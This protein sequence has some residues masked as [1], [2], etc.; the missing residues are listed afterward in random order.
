MRPVK[1]VALLHDICS[2]GKASLTNM[3]PILGGMGVE[4]CPIPTM[5][6]STHT[7]GYDAPAIHKIP[8]SYIRACADHYKEQEIQFD[9]IFVGYLGDMELIDSVIYF[10]ES[11]PDTKVIMDPIMGDHGKL[12][13]N[14]TEEYPKALRRL[15]PYADVLLPNLTE[16]FLLAGVPYQNPDDHRYVLTLCKELARLGAKNLV[17][18][19][20]E[21]DDCKK[22]IVLYENQAFL[23]IGNGEESGEYHGAGDAF[24]GMFVAKQ[25]Q[26]YSLLES[27]QASHA[28]VCACIRESM[29]YDYPEREGLL[30]ESTLKKL[31]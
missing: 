16:C 31:V 10:I 26:G 19:S 30:I 3:M 7:G 6:L 18:T 8:G 1:K 9:L 27:V 2:V 15:L 17:I 5:L 11:F 21:K 4:C 25:M 24:D 14:F 29:K 12:Y 23:Y 22:G 13:S 28:F 20:V